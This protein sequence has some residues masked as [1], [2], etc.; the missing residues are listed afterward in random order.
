MRTIIFERKTLGIYKQE[1]KINTKWLNLRILKIDQLKHQ[2]LLYLSLKRRGRNKRYSQV[3]NSMK[4]VKQK[5]SL[6]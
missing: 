5:V 1:Q 3:M 4:R 2:K 6:R